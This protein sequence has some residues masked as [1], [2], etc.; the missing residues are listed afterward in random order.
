M[1]TLKQ[2]YDTHGYVESW[3]LHDGDRNQQ[4]NKLS[5]QFFIIQFALIIKPIDHYNFSLLVSFLN[6]VRVVEGHTHLVS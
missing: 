5:S 1:S 4:N 2:E 3:H 6:Q